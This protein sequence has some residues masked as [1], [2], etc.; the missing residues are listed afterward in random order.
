MRFATGVGL[1]QNDGTIM[2]LDDASA[3]PAL[4]MVSGPT[5]SMRGAAYLGA[6]TGE[7]CVVV[8]IGGTTSDAG[9]LL[10]SGFPKLSA[11]D[12]YVGGCLVNSRIPAVAPCC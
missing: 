3:R 8:D 11:V 1:R 6:V 5:N 10:A 12:V 9:L 4:T 2:S 7:E